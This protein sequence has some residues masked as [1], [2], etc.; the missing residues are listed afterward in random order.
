M[1]LMLDTLDSRKTNL[2]TL[3]R[4]PVPAAT[5][6]YTPLPHADAV[7]R[8]LTMTLTQLPVHLRS[9]R[10]GLAR[11]GQRMFGVL[12][13][14]SKGDQDW[15]FCWGVR[16]S[17]D[18]SVSYGIAGGSSVFVCSNLCFAGD[19]VTV[20][21]KHTSRILLDVD[22]MITD[23]IGHGWGHY[24]SMDT[25]LKSLRGVHV[26]HDD[27]YAS[28]GVALGRGWLRSGELLK[29]AK[30]WRHAPHP[31][32]RTGDL[33]ALYQSINHALK[34]A[35]PDRAMGAHVR[36]HDH[37][38]EMREGC[39]GWSLSG[40]AAAVAAEAARATADRTAPDPSILNGVSP[41]SIH[42]A[43]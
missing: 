7:E 8:L 36:L 16:N 11:Q 38:L 13:F 20:F 19:A 17:Y 21:R 34:G 29:A 9:A 1:T 24:R 32:H 5:S 6:T 31:Q 39:K 28:L 30:Y 27:A 23:A 43:G 37:I 33:F 15:G 40:P 14:R 3:R 42:V 10:Y 22:E 41:S 25:D 12:E 4:V 26:S 35:Q 2:D 18:R